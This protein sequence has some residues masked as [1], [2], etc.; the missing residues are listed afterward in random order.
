MTA[1]SGRLE[2]RAD[3]GDFTGMRE[4]KQIPSVC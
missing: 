1:E 2:K 4:R 3:D